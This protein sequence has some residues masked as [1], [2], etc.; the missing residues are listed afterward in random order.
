[1]RDFTAGQFRT[2]NERQWRAG[3][4]TGA[5]VSRVYHADAV[6]SRRRCP[7]SGP[8]RSGGWIPGQGADQLETD[9]A[10]VVATGAG[11]RLWPA[12][13]HRPCGALDAESVPRRAEPRSTCRS[14]HPHLS[15]RVPVCLDSPSSYVASGDQLVQRG[16]GSQKAGLESP[17]RTGR[18]PMIVP[19]LYTW[20]RK[21]RPP[22][23]RPY[24]VCA[25]VSV[26]PSAGHA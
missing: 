14:A 7:G 10:T 26:R 23:R 4:V 5:W 6:G 18:L 3:G 11:A 25:R 19:T 1:V 22:L 13:E 17:L 8:R 21:V 12:R 24:S 9:T 20:C 2:P 15:D 16:F